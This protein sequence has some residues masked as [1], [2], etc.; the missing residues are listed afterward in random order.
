MVE[1]IAPKVSIVVPMYNVEKYVGFC[2]D[3][4][5]AQ[6]LEDIEII[7]VD[8]GSPDSSGAIAEEYSRRDH[9]VRV[10]HRENGGL[11]PARN[12]GIEC[13][14]GEYIGFVDS[15][16]WVDERMFFDLYRVASERGADIVRGGHEVWS[17]GKL[18]ARKPHPLAGKAL[19]GRD[20]IEPFRMLLYGRMP[21]DSESLSLPVEVWTSIYKRNL[22]QDSD[23]RFRDI[24]SEDTFF[25]ISVC[26]YAQRITYIGECGYRYR[27]DRQ[28]S[29]TNSFNLRTV[30]RYL[31]L[32][33]QLLSQAEGEECAQEARLRCERK[34][35]D[36]ARTLAF[37]V[38]KSD[39]TMDQKCQ[40]LNDFMISEE[41]AEHCRNYPTHGLPTYQALTHQLLVKG[42]YRIVLALMM[43]R[44]SLKGER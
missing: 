25:N 39:L 7:V 29:I 28:P 11:G 2:L 43:V 5:L 19:Q 42:R 34:I 23:V 13:A 4:L 17:N 1:S 16:D 10:V 3:S 33:R 32:A 15:D 18:I 20:E 38:A 41:F 40:V 21:E 31:G 24:L 37:Q 30:D 44:N 12:T 26:K 36:L 6:S 27:K 14:T 35:V 8:D 9:R 22:V